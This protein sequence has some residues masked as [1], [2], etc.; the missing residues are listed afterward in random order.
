[1]R[2]LKHAIYM[3]LIM[4]VGNTFFECML[5]HWMTAPKAMYQGSLGRSP[6]YEKK[7]TTSAEGAKQLYAP[8]GI[9]TRLQRVF[10]LLGHS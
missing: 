2:G 6:R 3:L 5:H 8:D 1:M 9:E 10:E 4:Q 7:G